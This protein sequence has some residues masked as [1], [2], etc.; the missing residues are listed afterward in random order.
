MKTNQM[1]YRSLLS[2][3]L[4]LVI[5]PTVASLSLE[6]VLARREKASPVRLARLAVAQAENQLEK[7]RFSG[8]ATLT[9]DPEVKT[10]TR[11]GETFAEEI[12]FSG[13]ASAKFAL[14]M[15]DLE[16]ERVAIAYDSLNAA[17][18]RFVQAEVDAFLLAYELYQDAWLT[19]DEQSVLS[20][21]LE[22]A[23]SY[24][25][26]ARER[27]RLGELSLTELSEAE[28][29]LQQ[30][31]E[32]VLAGELKLRLS[33]LQIA[34]AFDFDLSP[35]TPQLMAALLFPDTAS[36]PKP[37]ELAAWAFEQ[38]PDLKELEAGVKQIDSTLSRLAKTDLSVSL[39]GFGAM[40]EH[41]ASLS[42]TFQDPQLAA[43]Y[44]F[45]I[46][47]FG[48]V[49]AGGSGSTEDTWS[50][51]LSVGLSYTT[52][53]SDA[54]EAGALELERE[55][56]T[57][58]IDARKQELELIIRSRYQQWLKAVQ[59]LEQARRN[60]E[61]V[62]QNRAILESKRSLGLANDYDI[63]AAVASAGR[64]RF[65]LRAAEIEEKVQ[66]MRTAQSASYLA[67]VVEGIE[68]GD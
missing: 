39:K 28:E 30:A 13:T 58:R 68:A 19:Q 55:Q 37:P 9:L 8:D 47:S 1:L 12:G 21:E 17:R 53:R 10:T 14:G 35:E 51:G 59:S 26:A 11:I 18:K 61:Q 40:S 24:T 3:L 66:W 20:A 56:L 54:L 41:S 48:E 64:A 5:T 36:L 4:L 33:W 29:N 38:D 31:E 67:E 60:V 62:E 7:L 23:Q 49:A 16:K 34:Y 2:F 63:H 42:Y 32:A 52:G 22:A 44:S 43:S 50:V 57:A 45:P 25:K 46:V 65:S 27:F 6:E 15:T